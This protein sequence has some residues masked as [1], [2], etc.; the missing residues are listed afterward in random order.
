MSFKGGGDFGCLALPC[1]L[2]VRRQCCR[3]LAAASFNNFF[4][5]CH[6]TLIEMKHVYLKEAVVK[7]YG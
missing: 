5:L 4:K 3:K 7:G 2:F 6:A 1:C